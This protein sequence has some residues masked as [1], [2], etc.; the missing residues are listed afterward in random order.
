MKGHVGMNEVPTA[1]RWAC[2]L[3]RPASGLGAVQCW[4]GGEGGRSAGDMQSSTVR[5]EDHEG[6]QLWWEELAQVR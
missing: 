2:V 3:L 1:G 5:L 4:W 6:R